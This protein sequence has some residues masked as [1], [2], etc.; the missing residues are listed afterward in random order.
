[1]ILTI[2]SRQS[3]TP[4]FEIHGATPQRLHR[5]DF[6]KFEILKIYKIYTVMSLPSRPLTRVF[7]GKSFATTLP[8]STTA[9]S[10]AKEEKPLFGTVLSHRSY[11][12]LHAPKPPASF[13]PRVS[14]PLQRALQLKV[15]KWGGVVNFSWFGPEQQASNSERTSATAFSTLG[16]RLEIP[17]ITL[18]NLDDVEEKL[19]KHVEGPIVKETSEE[20]HLYVCTHGA[21]DCR[22][23][24]TGG[25]VVKVL[26]EEV[27]RRAK[28]DPS[29]IASRVKV[30]EVGHVGGHQYAANMLVYPHG[31]CGA[32]I[33]ID[34]RSLV[35]RFNPTRNA[36][37]VRNATTPMQVG[38]GN[39]AFGADVTGLQTLLP[40]AI[41]SSWGWKNDSLPPGKTVK[42]VEEYKG[43]SWLNHGRP[44]EYDFGGGNP[45]EQ[46][47]ISNPNRVNLGRVG[48]VFWSA[49]G[50]RLEV[51]EQDFSKMHQ[52]LDLWTG[53]LTSR[54]L[55]RGVEVTVG[56]VAADETSSVGVTIRS[57][58]LQDRRLGIFL[59]FPWNDGKAK[60]SAPFVGN[61]NAKANHT[62]ALE[63]HGARSARI[64]HT[65]DSAIF[66]TTV[67]GDR[68]IILRDLPTN[69]RYNV[70]PLGKLSTLSITMDYSI[71]SSMGALLDAKWLCGCIDWFD[72]SSGRRTA[73]TNHLIPYLMRVN[74]AG[75]T[76]PQESGLVNNGWYGKF[77]M[78]MY[79]WHSAHWALWNNWDLLRRS[80]DVYARFLDS[81]KQR[82]QK[83]QGWTSG[84][85]WPKMTDPSGRSAPG[86][87]NNL[88]IWQQPH[89]LIF[90]LYEYRAFPVRKTLEKWRDV[91]RE[92]ANWMVAFAWH[93]ATTG[94][95]D[96]GPPL[97]VVSEDTSPNATQN[98]ALELA[99][100]RLG[101]GIASTWMAKLG[102][103]IPGKWADVASNLAKLPTNDGT[104][105]IYESI[106]SDFWM[107]PAYTSDHPAFVGLHGWLP[108]TADLNV[109]MA[110]ATAKKVWTHWNITDC[111]GWDFPMLAM[112]AA[113]NGDRDK[114]I[115]WLLHPLFAFDDVGMPVGG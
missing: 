77:H 16:G 50:G 55:F 104:Y 56:T 5:H 32:R 36:F 2:A 82:A 67:A 92:T 51:S 48:L 43:V 107:N 80:S 18:K 99:Y 9:S 62:T 69:H 37:N 41:M 52:E 47:L 106:E 98:P 21:R 97:Y 95:Y 40:F 10:S 89:P 60:F 22:C 11:I 15:M 72:G 86:Q 26:R 84:A 24:N 23:G 35:N 39:F 66:D 76:P 93:N 49:A 29:G 78:E 64:V 110:K 113:R 101:L 81:S 4:H 34:R 114:A 59:D 103:D 19:R 68:F 57:S 108:P 96:L 30:G 8:Q 85:R 54:F 91:V 94:V 6:P 14:T 73:T 25:A 12:F 65:L 3:T 53:K 63:K 28:M 45:V 88:L 102:E 70:R 44:V 83:Q 13:P 74:E 79:F 33:I 17:E 7:A 109:T 71:H 61:W 115:E 46:W 105:A 31:D 112:S 20:L 100:W 75:N 38:N 42:D 111:W 58:L 90:A 27:A 1:M 87:I